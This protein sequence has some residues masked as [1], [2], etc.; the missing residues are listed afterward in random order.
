MDF[1][2][3]NLHIH[4]AVSLIILHELSNSYG[5]TWMYI[6]IA[7]ALARDLLCPVQGFYT[8][9]VKCHYH[10][11]S[12]RARNT[13]VSWCIYNIIMYELLES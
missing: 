4:F 10:H 11:C 9:Q 7:H 13:S 5:N 8:C 1:S 6:S 3:H 12:E 2:L